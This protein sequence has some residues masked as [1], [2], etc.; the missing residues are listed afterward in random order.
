[1]S[2]TTPDAA[3]TLSAQDL[4]ALVSTLQTEVLGLKTKV[5][6][7]DAQ[8]ASLR[9][10]IVN[11]THENE[12]LRRRIY[13]N[14]TERTNT[15]ELQLM[16]GDL[17]D[18]E[19]RLQ[20]ELDTAVDEAKKEADDEP[21]ETP[22]PSSK[23]SAKGRRDLSVS[24]LPK[25][26]LDIRNEEL[27]ALGGKLIGY[28]ETRQL[29]FRRG[30]FSVLVKRTAKYAMPGS[31]GT[32]VLGSSGLRVRSQSEQIPREAPSRRFRRLA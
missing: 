18:D 28:D 11:L 21:Q 2:S 15:S 20:K 16:L 14:K 10:T 3:T 6:E 5:S 29:M 17:L 8:N 23:K 24:Q 25:V 9:E 30:G 12:L 13:G 4:L 7:Q 31:D 26:L 32:T 22:P 27:E 1:V 19:K